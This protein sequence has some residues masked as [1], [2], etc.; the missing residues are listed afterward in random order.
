MANLTN[1]SVMCLISTLPYYHT[2]LPI[3]ICFKSISDSCIDSF[4]HNCYIVVNTTVVT[5]TIKEVNL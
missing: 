2:S 3:S 4:C 5:T 1:N